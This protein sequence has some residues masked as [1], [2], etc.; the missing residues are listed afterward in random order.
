MI[1]LLVQ[2]LW[3]QRPTEAGMFSFDESDQVEVFDLG[4]IRI[5]YSV[6]GP[7]QTLLEDLD[8]NGHPDYPEQV[9]QTAQEVLSF[10]SA[11]L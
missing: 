10:F 2:S 6:S 9:A 5:H 8:Q 4:E 3:A 1:V 11:R 7:N